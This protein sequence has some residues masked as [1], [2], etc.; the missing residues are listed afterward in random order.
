MFE[1]LAFAVRECHLGDYRLKKFFKDKLI[2]E[3]RN[4]WDAFDVRDR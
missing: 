1:V 3:S 4:V 2:E